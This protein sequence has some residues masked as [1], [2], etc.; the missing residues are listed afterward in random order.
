MSR[1]ETPAPISKETP[2]DA[3]VVEQHFSAANA[4]AIHEMAVQEKA[5]TLAHQL[6]YEGSLT[7]G[8]LEDEI[9]F[10]QQRSVEALLEA[11]KRLLLLK[12]VTP[13]GEFAKRVELLG[14]SY[15]SA[16]RFMQA[17]AKTAKSATVAVLAGQMKNSKA[18]L[19][20][21]TH[22][23]DV[24]EN[25]AELDDFDRMSASQLREKARELA[26]EKEA[27][28]KL[29]SK[30]NEQIDAKERE[31]LRQKDLK[32]APTDWPDRFKGLMDQADLAHRSIKLCLDSLEAVRVTAMEDE[33][34]TPEDE[35]S[36]QR[37]RETLAEHM[38]HIQRSCSERLDA[39]GGI[40]DKTLGAFASE[41]VWK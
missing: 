32:L 17:A 2:A 5:S 30:K 24:I 9:R 16:A 35:G 22:D 39:L 1:K 15:R 10:Y 19:E 18:F 20:L 4:L 28:E 21:I 26:A 14:F 23:D 3:N 36:L 8:A 37:A 25:L 13:H 34:S 27:S 11:G 31:L 38:L 6:G 33:A 40:F 12:E 41:G 7:V 29:V